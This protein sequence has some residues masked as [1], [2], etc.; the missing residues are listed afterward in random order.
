MHPTPSLDIRP[1]AAAALQ[2]GTPVAALGS[3]AI[4]HSLPWP[5]NLETVRRAQD[6][7][8]REGAVLAVVAVW[9]GRLTV[10]LTDGEVEALV[11]GGSALR[12]SRRDLAGAVVR[13][14]TAA[15]TVAASMYLAS[16]AGIRLL[17]AGAIGGAA[18]GEGQAWDV[19][20]DLVE[21]A[22]TPVAV[23]SAGGRS[24]LNLARTGEILESYGVPV[25]G[26]GADVLPIFYQRIGGHPAS[27]RADAPAEAAAL[28]SAHWAMGGAGVVLAQPTPEEAALSP[29]EL[30]PA[31]LE[32]EAQA[33][34][35]GVRARDLPSFLMGRLNRLTRGKALRAYQAILVANARLAAQVARELSQGGGAKTA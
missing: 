27:F 29:D 25:V 30:Q 1:E 33:A 31:L 19:S 34:K 22:R 14:L 2:A 17:A 24:V 3:A 32:V 6:A 5:A 4:A 21:L 10:G 26:Y 12:A 28:L 15:T 16:Q 11:H 7:A 18:R 23:V 9:R 13:G 8:R 35:Q 20:A